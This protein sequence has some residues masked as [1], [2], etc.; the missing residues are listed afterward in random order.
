MTTDIRK[1]ARR[2]I[3]LGRLE[4]QRFINA[5]ITNEKQL[6]PSRDFIT[7]RDTVT[8][9]LFT[10]NKNDKLTWAKDWP[11]S[12]KDLTA[13]QNIFDGILGRLGDTWLSCN[14]TDNLRRQGLEHFRKTTKT[15]SAS[16]AG[17]TPYPVTGRPRNKGHESNHYNLLTGEDAYQHIDIFLIAAALGYQLVGINDTEEFT[18]AALAEDGEVQVD[19]SGHPL[20]EPNGHGITSRVYRLRNN[21]LYYELGLPHILRLP[22]PTIV[23]YPHEFYGHIFETENTF[24]TFTKTNSDWPELLLPIAEYLQQHGGSHTLRTVAADNAAKLRAKLSPRTR[25]A[26]EHIAAI[27]LPRSH[28]PQPEQE[29]AYALHTTH[30]DTGIGEAFGELDDITDLPLLPTPTSPASSVSSVLTNSTYVVETQEPHR[31]RPLAWNNCRAETEAHEQQSPAT[32]RKLLFEDR[33]NADNNIRRAAAI[34]NERSTRFVIDIA[35]ENIGR[36]EAVEL[37]AELRVAAARVQDLLNNL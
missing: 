14:I 16:N 31:K 9:K 6:I 33:T 10:G 32:R 2:T 24:W 26:A 20:P 29:Q 19:N 23:Y 25:E 18:T 1:G 7:D 5:I 15:C 30:I 17:S 22:F 37:L 8:F 13:K 21:F 28:T 34:I 4:G 12:L 35:S 27:S 11:H 36:H 3:Y